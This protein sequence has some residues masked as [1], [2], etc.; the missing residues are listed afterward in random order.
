MPMSISHWDIHFFLDDKMLQ[1][2]NIII[3]VYKHYARN[4]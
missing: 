1:I 2:I 4:T 3:A